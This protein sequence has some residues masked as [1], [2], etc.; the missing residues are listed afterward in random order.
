[1][2]RKL[3]TSALSAMRPASSRGRDADRHAE[4]EVEEGA[5]EGHREGGRHA[6]FISSITGALVRKE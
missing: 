6:I 4:E 3:D 2:N 5:A 1:M